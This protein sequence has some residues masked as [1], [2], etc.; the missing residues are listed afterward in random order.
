[1]NAMYS[2][3]ADGCIHSLLKCPHCETAGPEDG[4]VLESDP[5]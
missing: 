4:P 1:M 5:L 2:Q 3:G